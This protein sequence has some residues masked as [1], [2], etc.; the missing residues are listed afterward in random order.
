[1]QRPRDNYGHLYAFA[2]E[3]A[4][5]F[6]GM[7]NRS[8]EAPVLLCIAYAHCHDDSSY[9]CDALNWWGNEYP[10]LRSLL[11]RLCD[12]CKLDLQGKDVEAHLNGCEYMLFDKWHRSNSEHSSSCN[13]HPN[14]R[15]NWS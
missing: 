13:E 2:Y 15:C 1:M 14:D 9:A 8:V 11:E 3:L 10:L 5:L 6:Q 7:G 12:L 4:V